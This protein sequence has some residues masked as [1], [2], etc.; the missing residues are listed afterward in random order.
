M[1]KV[2]GVLLNGSG[3]GKGWLKRGYVERGNK[4]GPN[5]VLSLNLARL[6]Y[7]VHIRLRV[8]V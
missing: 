5:R 1:E 3:R 8:P 2:H 7:I 4:I 6:L